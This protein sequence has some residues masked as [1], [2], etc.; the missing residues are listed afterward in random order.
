MHFVM[1]AHAYGLPLEQ[2]FPLKLEDVPSEFK[3][4]EHMMLLVG[5]A[6]QQ[7][8]YSEHEHA[9]SSRASRFS[10]S[11][12]SLRLSQL[13]EQCFALVPP[14]YRC[15]GCEDEMLILCRDLPKRKEDRHA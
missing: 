8:V 6:Q 9:T 3:G 2:N 12:L 7:V 5:K 1:C 10:P 14:D 11:E 13:V 15:Q 4:W